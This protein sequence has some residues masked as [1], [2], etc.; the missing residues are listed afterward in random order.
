[1]KMHIKPLTTYLGRKGD[2]KR[3]HSIKHQYEEHE[4]L[5][6]MKYEQVMKCL[7][8]RQNAV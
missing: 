4:I 7:P 2:F 5:Q 1:M 8:K 3:A 6:V